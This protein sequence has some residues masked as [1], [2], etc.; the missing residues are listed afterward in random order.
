M[1]LSLTNEPDTP[2]TVEVVVYRNGE[3]VHREL[4][5]SEAD[6][7]SVIEQWKEV[8]GTEF[9]IDDLAVRHG[10]DDILDPGEAVLDDDGG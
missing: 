8:S 5:E 7:A 6:A 4:C 3:V 10:P 9:Q 1:D 2:P